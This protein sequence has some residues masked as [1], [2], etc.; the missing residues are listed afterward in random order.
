MRSDPAENLKMAWLYVRHNRF[1]WPIA[2]FIALAGGGLQSFGLWLQSPIGSGLIGSSPFHRISSR[3]SS[4]AGGNTA[5]WVVLLAAGVVVGLAAVAFGAFAQASAIGGIAE[6]EF[7][8]EAD[9]RSSLA[10]GRY[11]CRRLFLLALA[12]IVTVAA[13][14]VPLYLVASIAEEG[15]ILPLLAWLALGAAFVLVTVPLGIVL[16]L[17]ARYLV[18]DDLPPMT[19]AA[20][21]WRLFRREWRNC[22]L[23]WLYVMLITLAGVI[24]T[25]LLLGVMAAALVPL[26]NASYTGHGVPLIMLGMLAFLVAWA[27][28]AAVS[29]V[30]AITGS[31]LWTETFMDLK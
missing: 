25:A 22:L 14:S 7:G 30:F 15:V 11:S 2:F 3:V 21:G 5:F 16:E 18:L 13:L 12:Y 31:A 4:Y 17:A 23:A 20:A 26:F 6:L 1:L 8:R 24:V 19:A 28:T 27:L 9:L 29:G 10:W